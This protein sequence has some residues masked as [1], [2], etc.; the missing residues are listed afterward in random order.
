MIVYFVISVI[1][2]IVDQAVKWWTVANFS[3]GQGQDLIPGIVNIF[4]IKNPG[5]A[6]GIL[7][8]QMLIFYV[9]TFIAVAAMAY[10]I[11]KDRGKSALASL[12]YALI[13]AGAL[14][15]FID[16]LRLG[17]VVDMFRLDFMQF[18]IFNVADMCLSIGV[19]LLFIYTLFIEGKEHASVK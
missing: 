12:A 8:G 6:W 1:A 5:A 9:I 15:N 17:Y 18:P 13:L 16:R 10:L 3:E 11:F 14:G 2:I 4:Y 19:A 7:E